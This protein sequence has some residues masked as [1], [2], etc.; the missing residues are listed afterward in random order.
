MKKAATYPLCL[1]SSLAH[2]SVSALP[3]RKDTKE[4]ETKKWS[5]T[6]LVLILDS[7][8]HSP[9]NEVDY[10]IV[11]FLVFKKLV[12]LCEDEILKHK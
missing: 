5:R 2:A 4:W 1:C 12:L 3:F 11:Q 9:Y 7:I 6:F 8:I 10:G